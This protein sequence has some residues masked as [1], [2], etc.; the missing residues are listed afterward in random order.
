MSYP[1]GAG[2]LDHTVNV[3]NSD[4][5]TSRTGDEDSVMPHNHDGMGWAVL[6]LTAGLVMVPW[7]M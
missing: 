5:E 1:P 4:R 3:N 6:D 7:T 2:H